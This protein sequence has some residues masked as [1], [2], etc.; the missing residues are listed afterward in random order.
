MPASAGLSMALF[1]AYIFFTYSVPQASY[2]NGLFNGA[3][4]G[5]PRLIISAIWFSA[6][7]IIF[8]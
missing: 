3:V 8:K 5:V 4:F 6:F 1:I 2:I 7:M